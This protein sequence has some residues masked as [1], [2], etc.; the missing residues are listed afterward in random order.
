MDGERDGEE[1][2]VPGTNA[3]TPSREE[4]KGRA[5]IAHNELGART[6]ELWQTLPDA[7][8]PWL[9]PA[10]AQKR[11]PVASSSKSLTSTT[12]LPSMSSLFPPTAGRTYTSPD[13]D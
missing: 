3:S 4:R 13:T 1:T 5:Q 9:C 12:L 11:S 2:R 7:P 8:Q 6:P 10:Q